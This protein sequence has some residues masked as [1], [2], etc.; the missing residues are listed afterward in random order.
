MRLVPGVKLAQTTREKGF[1]LTL[2]VTQFE[3][4]DSLS[5]IASREGG[6][7]STISLEGREAKG[8]IVRFLKL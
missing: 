1:L 4:D 6:S 8:S 2:L 7:T 5:A 3:A